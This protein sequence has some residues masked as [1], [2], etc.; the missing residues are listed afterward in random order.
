M[1]WETTPVYGIKMTGIPGTKGFRSLK[2]KNIPGEEEMPA[3]N[4]KERVI[5]YFTPSYNIPFSPVVDIV[6]V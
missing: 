5:P 4:L 1:S 3:Q 6:K 2:N